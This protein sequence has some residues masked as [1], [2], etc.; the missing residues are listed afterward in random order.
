MYI[1]YVN[2]LGPSKNFITSD[3]I[4]GPKRNEKKNPIHLAFE[5]NPKIQKNTLW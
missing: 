2:Y 4:K 5:Q 3:S 1:Y